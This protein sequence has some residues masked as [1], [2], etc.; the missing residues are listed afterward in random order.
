M[1]T[2]ARH[3]ARIDALF[4][5]WSESPG[6]GVAVAVVQ[7]GDVVYQ[8]SYGLANIENGVALT[9]NSVLRLG[10]TTKHLTATCLLIL[11]NRGLLSLDDAVRDH[12]P[13]F[14][15]FDTPLTLRHLLTMTSGLRDHLTLLLLDGLDPGHFIGKQALRRMA[16]AP[17][18][19]VFRP[20]ED[21][22]YSNT[23]YTLLSEIVERVSGQSLRD[24]MDRELFAPLGMTQTR[25]VPQMSETVPDMA[26]GYMPGPGG[27]FNAGFMGVYV[28]GAGGVNAPLVDMIRWFRNYRDDQVFGPDYRQR[29]EA[30]SHLADGQLS[31]YRLG[32]SVKNHRGVKAVRHGGGMPGYA[33]DFVFYPEPD[34]GVILLA[35]VLDLRIYALAD[36]IADVLLDERPVPQASRPDFVPGLY[37]SES[38]DLLVLL[39]EETEEHAAYILGERNPLVGDGAG[40]R[41]TKN[42]VYIEMAGR[43]GE[44]GLEV[45][46]GA[47]A[48]QRL[49]SIPDPLDVPVPLPA[50]Y[51][52]FAGVYRNERLGI[53]QVVEVGGGEIA[54]R[55]P[56]RIRE[57]VWN[58]L[59]A[60]TGDLFVAPVEGEPSCTNVV[61]RFRRDGQ[62][63]VCG[64][65]Y[66]LSRCEDLDFEKVARAGREAKT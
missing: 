41:S 35:N 31:D 45:R 50:D 32:I 14:P 46:I 30:E 60:V 5:P 24:F 29:M 52:D 56:S 17:L 21:V 13:E 15:D 49:R 61:I 53:E 25:L 4:S 1:S 64:L 11:E 26:K 18:P 48:A 37:L 2:A 34:I 55:L 43:G 10:S 57:L 65:R 47:R 27:V 38:G 63:G 42:P 16:V 8:R 7:G 3:S 22:V 54:V 39:A 9:E 23:N 28:D 59:Y 40:W 12:I 19:L 66:S 62:G 36:Q 58:K 44:V 33:C 20:G 51:E 6:P